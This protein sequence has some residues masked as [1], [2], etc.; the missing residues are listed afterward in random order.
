MAGNG[1]LRTSAGC[2]ID[3]FV[4]LF[5]AAYMCTFLFVPTSIFL[6]KNYAIG[7]INIGIIM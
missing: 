1:V 6:L 3:I 2:S 5:S 7:G 4:L